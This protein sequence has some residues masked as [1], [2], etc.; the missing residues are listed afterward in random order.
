MGAFLYVGVLLFDGSA[1]AGM[2]I[3]V[4]FLMSNALH[5]F[6]QLMNPGRVGR[7]RR[8]GPAAAGD[9]AGCGAPGRCRATRAAPA[10]LLLDGVAF[11]PPGARQPI[12]GGITL[13]LP[14][15]AVCTSRAPTGSARARCC[16]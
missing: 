12:I 9:A 3:S 10:G 1:T 7:R 14:P 16:G 15:G 8:L 13:H 6:S 5:P 11:H 4:Y 2:L